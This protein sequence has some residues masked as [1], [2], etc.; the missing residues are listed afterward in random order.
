MRYSSIPGNCRCNAH[1]P[2][3][4]SYRFNLKVALYS[5]QV[6]VVIGKNRQM[7]HFNQLGQYHGSS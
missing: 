3:A 2:S 6:A 5:L 1:I 4:G 7:N